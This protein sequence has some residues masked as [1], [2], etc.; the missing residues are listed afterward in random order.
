M[1]SCKF[2]L[3]QF[4]DMLTGAFCEYT[5]DVF[6]YSGGCGVRHR[7]RLYANNPIPTSAIQCGK[8]KHRLHKMC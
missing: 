6:D 1:V 4:I 3:N 2:P 8:P 7:Y 5:I